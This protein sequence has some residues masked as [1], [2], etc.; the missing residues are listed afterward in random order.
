GLPAAALQFAGDALAVGARLLL[1]DRL[2]GSNAGQ[3]RDRDDIQIR[4]S[5]IKA[6]STS[7]PTRLVFDY[8]R[9]VRLLNRTDPAAVPDQVIGLYGG[10]A[11]MFAYSGLSFR[12]G[13]R[14]LALA[15]RLRRPGHAKDQFDHDCLVCICNYLEGRWDD[16]AGTVADE[17]VTAALR[18]GGLWEVNT[19][20][21]LDADRRLRRGDFAGARR[22]IEQLADIAETYGFQFARTNSACETMLLQLEER[23]LDA[24]LDAANLYHTV[25][26]DDLLRVLALG[27]K[28][29]A[30][31]LLGDAEAAARTLRGAEEV[32]EHAPIIPPWHL[33]GYA[34]GRLLH[35]LAVLEAAPGPD[36]AERARRSARAA[37]RLAAKVAVQRG[38]IERLGANL[39]WLLGETR[40]AGRTLARAI[41][42]C[43][44]LGAAPEL[45][46][47]HLD[48]ATWGIDLG[49]GRGAA[50]HLARAR[51]LY[52]TL[53]L[54]WGQTET[55]A[56]RAA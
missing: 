17:V 48:A 32:I 47:A 31:V 2:F 18:Y 51:Q 8:F 14:Y 11:A 35:D 1:P 21:G 44:R 15:D 40:D 39:H 49:D 3:A 50:D 26:Q 52:D 42:T 4:Y 9:A 20:L 27:S 16:D 19:Y 24:A 56:R 25:A 53:G 28:A 33:S 43:E 12:L 36:A 34:V 54:P 22:R 30:Q 6:Q 46:R 5:R 23:R 10:F 38:E 37:Q 41:A 55:A 13:R 45:A 29:K 7:D